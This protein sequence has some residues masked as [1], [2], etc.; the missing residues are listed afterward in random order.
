[1]SGPSITI[2]CLIAPAGDA[3]PVIVDGDLGR[4]AERKRLVLCD[5][6]LPGMTGLERSL[7]GQA[8]WV[9]ASAPIVVPWYDR[10]REI[11]LWRARL[12]D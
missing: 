11:T 2:A 10:L 5:V 8:S 3:E 6:H 1:M 12:P 4:N 7:D 9:M